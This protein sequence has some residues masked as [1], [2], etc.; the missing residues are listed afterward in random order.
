MT[1]NSTIARPYA[2]AVFD[3]ARESGDLA[4]WS[5]ALAAAA[6]VVADAAAR[7]F[8]GK[9]QLSREER[10]QFVLAVCAGHDG[11]AL[12][13]SDTGRSL[14]QLLAENDRLTALPDISARFDS[15]KTQA[16]NRIKVTVV[17]AGE[18]DAAQARKIAQALE[19]KLGRDVDLQLE[20]D[21]GLIG[22]A[23]IHA[24]GMVIDGSVRSRLQ[25]LAET[26]VD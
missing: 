2:K 22:G 17:A 5:A 19:H 23:V 6:S 4:G 12:L 8:L 14:L 11:E 24:E 9:P 16:E 15:L 26:L 21:P 1:D 3:I 13:A 18:I 7:R 10:A 25:R 20:V